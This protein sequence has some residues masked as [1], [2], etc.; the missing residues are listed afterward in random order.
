MELAKPL[1][2]LG[3]HSLGFDKGHHLG[4][5]SERLQVG[6]DKWF[7][8]QGIGAHTAG[9]G[10]HHIQVR[11]DVWGQVGFVDDEQVALG[12][13]RATFAGDFF[14]R[15]HVNHVDGEVAE[16]GA[17]GG[18][19]VVAAAL[20][21]HDVGIGVLDQHAV[22]G[23]Q[24]DGAVFTDGGVRA[25]ARLHTHDALGGQG[26]ADGQDALVFLGVDVVG[27]G[28]QVVFFAHGFAQHFQQRGFARPHRAADA[29]A[30]G[31]ELFG[32]MGDVVQSG[33]GILLLKKE[34]LALME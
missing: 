22:N 10:F 34:L 27:D 1:I 20:N 16:L 9:V 32:A 13:A 15:S 3:Q 4:Q 21:K 31:W 19:Q 25:A 14:A 5:A 2:L 24:V 30:Q 6:H 29:D 18:G 33:H 23:F 28:H 8:T 11:A 7:E 12:D 26:T 17:E